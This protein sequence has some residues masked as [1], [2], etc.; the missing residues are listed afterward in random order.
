MSVRELCANRVQN[1]PKLWYRVTSR[2]AVHDAD[3]ARARRRQK[4]R[5]Y[6]RWQGEKVDGR[7]LGQMIGQKRSVKVS[8]RAVSQDDAN[9]E[10][11]SIAP[12]QY[13]NFPAE[14]PMNAGPRAAVQARRDPALTCSVETEAPLSVPRWPRAVPL[15]LDPA[16]PQAHHGPWTGRASAFHWSRV[17]HALG[18]SRNRRRLR[19]R[20]AAT[21]RSTET[22]STSAISAARAVNLT[23]KLD[24]SSWQAPLTV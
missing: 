1:Q 21:H 9:I 10:P 16:R 12:P 5:C 6:R 23:R 24:C 4:K 7:S 11:P 3:G 19:L 2:S 15:T 14:L 18:P 20:A 8:G 17:L 13:P 22:W